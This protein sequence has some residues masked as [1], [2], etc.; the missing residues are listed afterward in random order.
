MIRSV[1][2]AL[3]LSLVACGGLSPKSRDS[4]E[5]ATAR[6]EEPSPPPIE[7]PVPAFAASMLDEAVPM[8]SF[9]EPEVVAESSEPE[10]LEPEV[11]LARYSLR[12]GE[13]LHH[14]ALWSGVPVE[15]IA[16]LS[17]LDLGGDYPV[18][19]ELLLPAEGE[20]LSEIDQRREAHWTRRV[21]GYLASRGGAVSTEFYK[22]RTGDSAWS[23]ARSQ[24][25][26][27]VWM[28]EAYNPSIDLERLRPGQELM[29]PVLADI[30]VD[31]EGTTP[32]A[33]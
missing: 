22:V 30:V 8:A 32:D 16:E 14:Y 13:T 9:D 18:G 7:E 27:P 5:S 3:M 11:A 24:Y 25:G 4:G 19:T 2:V 17:G 1:P 33:E 29:V 12:R 6:I 28:L 15:D 20:A 23:I 10:A 21:D 31:A 26:M